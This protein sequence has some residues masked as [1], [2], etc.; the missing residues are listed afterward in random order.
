MKRDK[1]DRMG[2]SLLDHVEPYR[3][4]DTVWGDAYE[5]TGANKR[6]RLKQTIARNR[7]MLDVPV[8]S[9]VRQVALG[10]GGENTSFS[11]PCDWC[12]VLVGNGFADPTRLLAAAVYPALSG[13]RNVL[14]VRESGDCRLPDA[15][16]AGLELGGLENFVQCC[17]EELARIIHLAEG[18]EGRGVLLVLGAFSPI[19]E[20]ALCKADLPVSRVA[21]S[22]G[23]RNVRAMIDDVHHWDWECLGW[24]FPEAEFLLAGAGAA[25]VAQQ[26]PAGMTGSVCPEEELFSGK[27]DLLLHPVPFRVEVSPAPVCLG[28]GQEGVW[29]WPELHEKMFQHV[30]LLV[31][32]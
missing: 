14:V 31:S 8:R 16:L 23:V 21:R 24:A 26:L 11:A 4:S 3:I 15:F 6:S 10:Q 25:R 30:R 17:G 1:E 18:E 19:V 2:R 7:S 28:P 32:S 12:L 13:V 5:R 20:A 9:V 27:C 29:I 22:G